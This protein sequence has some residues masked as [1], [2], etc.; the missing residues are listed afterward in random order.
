M[1]VGYIFGSHAQG[2]GYYKDELT[3]EKPADWDVFT[4]KE[5]HTI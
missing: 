2:V 5:V 3:T 4:T 1:K